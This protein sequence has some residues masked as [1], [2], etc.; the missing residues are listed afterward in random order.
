MIPIFTSEEP[1]AKG[2][3]LLE[4][5]Q[6]IKGQAGIK[7]QLDLQI[8]GFGLLTTNYTTHPMALE[9][10]RERVCVRDWASQVHFM[11]I[12][13]SEPRLG[14]AGGQAGNVH[15]PLLVSPGTPGTP[16]SGTQPSNVVAP[17]TP[18]RVLGAGT[19]SHQLVSDK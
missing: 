1:E 19:G 2:A 5:V 9:R 7:T 16:W 14:A 17:S 15:T 4:T 8:K 6:I 18:H 11:A 10:G 12:P 3:S 13:L